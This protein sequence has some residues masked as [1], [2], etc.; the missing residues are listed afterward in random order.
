MISRFMP[1]VISSQTRF[2]GCLLH[3]AVALF[4]TLLCVLLFATK[5]FKCRVNK[6]HVYGIYLRFG[7][8]DMSHATSCVYDPY[9]L[10]LKKI[11]N[12]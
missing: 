8:T 1:C 7:S 6:E 11:Q 2:F 9:E 4:P 3:F 10:N 5:C 12:V